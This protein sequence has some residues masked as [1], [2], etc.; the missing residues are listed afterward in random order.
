M[1]F[2][3]L[4]FFWSGEKVL[5]WLFQGFVAR[6]SGCGWLVK[7]FTGRHFGRLQESPAHSGG[8]AV[9]L[10][11]SALSGARAFHCISVTTGLFLS[12]SH[13]LSSLTLLSVRIIKRLHATAHTLTTNTLR[14]VCT[15]RMFSFQDDIGGDISNLLVTVANNW[16]FNIRPSVTP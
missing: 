16:V 9:S 1:F 8:V 10:P 13:G 11:P 4:R 15:W 14:L 2:L 7:P 5:A 12:L 3:N 6:L